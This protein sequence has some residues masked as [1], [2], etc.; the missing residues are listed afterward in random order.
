MSPRDRMDHTPDEQQAL[1]AL[2][3]LPRPAGRD[4]ARA[5]AREAF[6]AAAAP[7]QASAEHGGGH[8]GEHGGEHPDL[9]GR[10]ARRGGN[11]WV[12]LAAAAVIAMALFGIWQTA[13]GPSMIW[14]VTDVVAADGVTGLPGQGDMVDGRVLVTGP[15]SELE[16][17][18]GDELRFRMI[19]GTEI[20]LP[21]PPRRW[22]PG[23]MQLVVRRGE[24]YGTTAGGGLTAPLHVRGQQAEA[25]IL[26]TTFAVF[27]DSLGT[28]VCLWEGDVTLHSLLAEETWELQE[29]TKF[30]VYE[31]GSVSGP[32][33]LDQ[34][35]TMKLQMTAEQGLLP[36]PALE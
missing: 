27:E 13:T 16:L 20:E 11:W 2:R 31:D 6:L 7:V 18:L 1:D 3:S 22:H 29:G 28:C 12:P 10:T 34:M 24:I 15:E 36:E 25:R 8:G 17:Q 30:Y 35:E 23:P 26:G 19:P 14:R 9:R 5:R 32:L 33:P 21:A 4:A